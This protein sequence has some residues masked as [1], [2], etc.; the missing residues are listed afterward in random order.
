MSTA[1]CDDWWLWRVWRQMRLHLDKVLCPTRHKVGHFGDVLPSQSLSIGLVLKNTTKANNTR[2]KWQKTRKKQHKPT[3]NRRNW[4]VCISLCT[5]EVN[6]S[7]QNISDYLSFYP[8][9]NWS[10]VVYCSEN[11]KIKTD[12]F[13]LTTRVQWKQRH[14]NFR[15]MGH[16]KHIT[17]WRVGIQI[18]CIMYNV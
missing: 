18:C 13:I 7:A 10:N 3:V 16:S 4:C 8:P 1:V 12:K 14:L 6:N 9:D 2:T 11:G 17:V 15:R 5:N